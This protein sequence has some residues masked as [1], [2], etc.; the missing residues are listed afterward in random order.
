MLSQAVQKVQCAV[1]HRVGSMLVLLPTSTVARWGAA[2]ALLA[3]PLSVAGAAL[4]RAVVPA[5]TAVKRGRAPRARRP[6]LHRWA[7]AGS[8]VHRREAPFMVGG[9]GLTEGREAAGARGECGRSP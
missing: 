6:Q 3:A 5:A 4:A 1:Q 9:E 8:G 2:T 7:A